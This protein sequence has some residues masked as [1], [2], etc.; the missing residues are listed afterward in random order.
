[1]SEITSNGGPGYYP[2]YLKCVEQLRALEQ[3]LNQNGRV[4]GRSELSGTIYITQDDISVHAIDVGQ[5]LVQ[6]IRGCVE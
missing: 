2:I 1:M 4:E 5:D 3:W 6:V